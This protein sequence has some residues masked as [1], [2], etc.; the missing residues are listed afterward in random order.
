M[1]LQVSIEK[2][3]ANVLAKIC[4]NP[5]IFVSET[6]IH[7]LVAKSFMGI[8]QLNSEMLY[9][10]KA[11]IGKNSK[12]EVS[13]E[14]YK[15]ML[16]HKEYGH[17][18]DNGVKAGARSDIVI[19]NEEQIAS[20]DDPINLKSG[21]KWIRPDYIFEFGTEKCAGSEDVF[22]AHLINDIKKTARSEK[23]GYV[24][25]IQRNYCQSTGKPRENNKN[26]YENY[27]KVIQTQLDTVTDKEKQ[28][29]LILLVDLGS[30]KGRAITKEGKVKI[31]E[32]GKFIGIHENEVEKR[33][34]SALS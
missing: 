15:T 8:Q 26:K 11:T 29:I 14:T 31:F 18:T 6:D 12:G 23:K 33:I 16:V 5:S 22:K 20:I 28:K 2:E 27:A 4:L 21:G 34:Y 19:F 3:L 30:E 13:A 10:T 17:E 24:I 32:N 7:T 1:N 9:R 25:H